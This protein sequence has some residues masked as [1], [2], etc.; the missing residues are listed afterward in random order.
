MPEE[1]DKMPSKIIFCIILMVLFF[2]IGYKVSTIKE[3]EETY[4]ILQD[5]DH[6]DEH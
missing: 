2:F 1:R 5:A 3:Q 6:E 4:I